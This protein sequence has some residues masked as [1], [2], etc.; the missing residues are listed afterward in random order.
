MLRTLASAYP[1]DALSAGQV[2]AI[3][4][5]AVSGVAI[6]LALVYLAARPARQRPRVAATPR[7]QSLSDA[8]PLVPVA[9]SRPALDEAADHGEVSVAGHV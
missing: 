5:A 6:W 9:G 1:S 4:F 7:D 3:V 8:G 2:A